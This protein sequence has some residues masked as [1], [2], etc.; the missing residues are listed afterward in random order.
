M[1]YATTLDEVLALRSEVEMM[2]AALIAQEEAD[3]A[4]IT[5]A[6]YEHW[7]EL[8]DKAKKL[9]LDALNGKRTAP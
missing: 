2:Q 4:N 1:P 8:E 3:H 9:R 7:Q 5:R 6:D